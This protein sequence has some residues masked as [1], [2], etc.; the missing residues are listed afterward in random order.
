MYSDINV[1]TQLGTFCLLISKQNK[2][3]QNV[4][5]RVLEKCPNISK[6]KVS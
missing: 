5:I 1:W 2:V 3:S 4:K 6:K